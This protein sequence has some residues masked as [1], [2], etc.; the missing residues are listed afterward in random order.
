ME[1]TWTARSVGSRGKPDARFF[2]DLVSKAIIYRRVE[3]IVRQEGFPAYRANVVAY[4]VALLS[5]HYGGDLSLAYVWSRQDVSSALQAVV[6]GWAH[7]VFDQLTDSA[8]QR[9]VTEWCKKEECWEGV[10]QLAVDVLLDVPEV[11]DAS[12]VDF[13]PEEGPAGPSI[14]EMHMIS[15]AMDV[16]E[17][18]WYQMAEWG[19]GSREL[20]P[21][22]IKLCYTM[23]EKASAK[24]VP[25]PT[26]T[27]AK[28]AALVLR[29]VNKRTSLL[30]ATE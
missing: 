2:R 19:S 20:T 23:A 30:G 10:R 16:E 26:V 15:A 25:E 7:L 9:N 24:W 1:G 22:Q 11:R 21:A 3:T 8:G 28:H 18:T 4:T 12:S 17:E 27:Q 13:G 5:H 29:R 14:E 6:R